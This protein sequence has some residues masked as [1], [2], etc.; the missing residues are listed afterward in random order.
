MFLEK[1]PNWVRK[2]PEKYAE[3]LKYE[4]AQLA[5]L[6]PH[7]G[8]FRD[9]GTL[10]IEGPIITSNKNQYL[11]RVVYP[12]EYPYKKPEGYVL[13]KDV[14]AFCSLPQNRGHNYHN[15]GIDSKH[16]LHLCLLG[17]GDSVNKGWT[18]NQ[19]GITILEYAIL[20]VHAYEY[21]RATGKWPLRE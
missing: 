21:K 16:G 15:Y 14:M 3:R 8:F 10:I 12:E 4:A 20:W 5:L 1:F 11:L 19:T 7:V 18:L 13:D 6:F 9:E 2:K 17:N